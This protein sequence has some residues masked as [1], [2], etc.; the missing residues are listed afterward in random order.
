M[1]R[2]F[3]K[4]GGQGWSLLDAKN[5]QKRKCTECFYSLGELDGRSW[6]VDVIGEILHRLW[7]MWPGHK[8]V[9]YILEL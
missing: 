5:V 3:V 6:I 1:G 2:F 8:F 9:M 7:T 4:A